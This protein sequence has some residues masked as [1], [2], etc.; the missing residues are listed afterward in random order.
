MYVFNDVYIIDTLILNDCN[1]NY[2]RSRPTIFVFYHSNYI[3]LFTLHTSVKI[4]CS[5]VLRTLHYDSFPDENKIH[6][7]DRRYNYM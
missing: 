2:D 6:I 3:I 1:T 5:A 4:L 7:D